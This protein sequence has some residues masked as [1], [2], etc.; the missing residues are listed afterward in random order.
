MC[1]RDRTRSG[2]L[3]AILC[4]LLLLM[5]AAGTGAPGVARAAD[6]ATCKAVRMSD[7]GWTDVTATTAV[8]SVILEELG[9]AP[10]ITV[11]SVPV[12]FASMKNKDVDV[13][14][15]NWMPAMAQDRDP[16]VKDGSVQ[17]VRMNLDGAKYTLAV[18]EALYQAGL[19][20]FNDIR[21]FAGPLN[22]A[23]YGIEPGN[24]GNRQVLTLIR[25]NTHGLGDFKLIESSEQGMP[26]SYTHLTLPTNREV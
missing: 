26:V 3:G 16:F 20:D 15:G 19:H 12:T 21:K 10:K 6:P 5:I 1:I 11:L 22:H 17:V 24:D 18:P 9:Y 2:G 13:F 23:I 7:I 8:T 25:N 14:L 4:V